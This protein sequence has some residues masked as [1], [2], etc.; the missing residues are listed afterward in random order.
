MIVDIGTD[1]Y[2]LTY[3]CI[4][5]NLATRDVHLCSKYLGVLKVVLALNEIL[6]RQE[7]AAPHEDWSTEYDLGTRYVGIVGVQSSDMQVLC[8]DEGEFGIH[9]TDNL[10]PDLSDCKRLGRGHIIYVLYQPGCC[11]LNVDQTDPLCLLGRVAREV[12]FCEINKVT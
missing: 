3:V 2:N 7:V 12:A 6:D 8:V 10:D 9:H 1:D 4:A 5:L 11:A